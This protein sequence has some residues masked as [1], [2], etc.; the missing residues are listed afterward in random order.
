MDQSGGLEGM[1]GGFPAQVQVYVDP[2]PRADFFE[3]RERE[4]SS[5]R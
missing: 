3:Y 2:E 1:A 4:F 5:Y